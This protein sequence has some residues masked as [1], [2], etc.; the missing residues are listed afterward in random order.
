MRKQILMYV[1]ENVNSV[2]MQV[3]KYA[4]AGVDV[5]ECRC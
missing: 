5:W 1:K 2:E 4:V 3:L